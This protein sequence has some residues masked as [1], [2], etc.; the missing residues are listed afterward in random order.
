ML[1]PPLAPVHPL[2]FW[3]SGMLS[4]S[5]VGQS[6]LVGF[7]TL[8]GILIIAYFSDAFDLSFNHMAQY[9]YIT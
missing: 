5:F 6:H 7:T 3:L 9:F 2:L 4:G 8:S 1:L